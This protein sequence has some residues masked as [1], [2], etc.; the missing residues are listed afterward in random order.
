VNKNS[1]QPTAGRPV[2]VCLLFSSNSPEIKM[3]ES[4]LNQIIEDVTSRTLVGS[5]S[6]S[7]EK[8][9]EEIA[10]ETLADEEF[11]ESLRAL[12]RA[13]AKRIMTDLAAL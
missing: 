9:A 7:I 5:I 13:A 10:K 2:N 8:I 6:I 1:N 11:R 4:K 12:T 3:T